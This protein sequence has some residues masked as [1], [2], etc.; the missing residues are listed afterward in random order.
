MKMTVLYSVIFQAA[1][2]LTTLASKSFPNASLAI[3]LVDIIDQLNPHL[4][5]IEK[6]RESLF[7]QAAEGETQEELS[8]KFAD[9][10]NKTSVDVE[11]DPITTEETDSAGIQFTV[12]EIASIRFLF[13]KTKQ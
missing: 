3:K 4:V 5:A 2:T 8:K 1:P 9:Y 6:F 10:L 12:R 7:A 13:A 11:I